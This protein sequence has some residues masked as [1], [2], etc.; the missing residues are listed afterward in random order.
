MKIK[1]PTLTDDKVLQND[2]LIMN[3]LY[4]Y[5]LASEYSQTFFYKGEISSLKYLIGE[6]KLDD[7]S[8]R[9]EIVRTLEKMYNRYFD[10]VSVFC[11][12]IPEDLESNIFNVVIA[13]DIINNGIPNSL[14]RTINVVNNK[15]DF[16]KTTNILLYK[17]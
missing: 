13:I 14:N 16:L 1:L 17:K 3:K 12:I 10:E 4:E 6:Y 2:I 5:F 7:D 11:D 9:I 15:I 8:L